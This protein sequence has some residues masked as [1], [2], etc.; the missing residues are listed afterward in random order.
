MAYRKSRL[1]ESQGRSRPSLTH[2]RRTRPSM[3]SRGA[4]S[5]PKR[6][7]RSIAD[8]LRVWIA[9]GEGVRLSGFLLISITFHQR[10]VNP[11][12]MGISW[13]FVLYDSLLRSAIF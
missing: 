3:A 2:L 11:R 13:Q 6:N 8:D 10:V 12:H 1:T 5:R 9:G 4:R 7:A